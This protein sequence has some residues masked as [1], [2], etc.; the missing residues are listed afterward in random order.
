MAA[1]SFLDLAYDVLRESST[2]LTY[3]EIWDRGREQVLINKIKTKG[4]TPWRSLGAQLYVEVR[5]NV[6][7][8]FIK[9]GKRPPRFF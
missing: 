3:Q 1:Y 4:K 7:S 2:P 9:V 5:D 6:R 8:R